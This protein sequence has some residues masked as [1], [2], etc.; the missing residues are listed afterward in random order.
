MIRPLAML[1]VSLLA[2]GCAPNPAPVAQPHDDEAEEATVSFIDKVWRVSDSPGV[3]RGTL[4]VFLSDGTLVI[5][6]RNSKPMLGT[7]KG[8]GYSLTMVEEGIEYPTD[9]MSLTQNEF[10]IASKNPGGRLEITMVRADDPN[11]PAA[12]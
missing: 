7:W 4:Y 6:S 10:K 5:T 8:V 1:V 2:F 12:K 3:A 9:V 11:A